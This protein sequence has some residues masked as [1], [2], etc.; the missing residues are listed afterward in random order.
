MPQSPTVVELT[1]AADALRQ[2]EGLAVRVRGVFRAAGDYAT[3][4][5]LGDIA[6]RLADEVTAIER[7]IAAAKP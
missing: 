4:A 5:R 3:A 1:A 2:A 7:T 6:V